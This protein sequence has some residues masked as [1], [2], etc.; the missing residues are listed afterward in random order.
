MKK[1]K[2]NHGSSGSYDHKL[3]SL[4]LGYRSLVFTT[5]NTVTIAGLYFGIV[6]EPER[7]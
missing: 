5:F 6:G 1:L 4:I 7:H 2:D 3:H